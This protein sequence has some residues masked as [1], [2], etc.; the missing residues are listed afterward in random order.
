MKAE[1]VFHLCDDEVR[2][3]PLV[4]NLSQNLDVGECLDTGQYPLFVYLGGNSREMYVL[5]ING[6]IGF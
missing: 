2:R 6:A 3:L 4:Y 1:F 5:S